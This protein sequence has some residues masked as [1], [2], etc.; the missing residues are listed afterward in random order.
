[1]LLNLVKKI[2]FIYIITFYSLFAFADDEEIGRVENV[3]GIAEIVNKET[4]TPIEK[5]LPVHPSDTIVTKDKSLVK[6]LFF[7]GADIILYDN[8][9]LK[10][11]EYKFKLDSNKKNLSGVF[12]D[13]KGKIRFFVKPDKNVENDVKYKTNNAV[14]GIRGTG[15]VIV[16]QGLEKTQLVVTSGTVDFSNPA[17]P[18]K[19]I[20]VKE[21]QW[22]E[23]RGEKPPAP[24]K[25]VTPE[26]IKNLALD[27]PEGFELT[28]SGG[29]E[30]DED[31]KSNETN[32]TP[33]ATPATG[34]AGS[35]AAGD[36]DDD[37]EK[38]ENESVNSS[39][40]NE[41]NEVFRLGPTLSVGLYQYFSVG[42]EARLFRFLGLSANIGGSPSKMNMKDF[43]NSGKK[44]NDNSQTPINDIKSS[45]MH[46]EVRAV[47]YPFR[48]SFFIGSAFGLRK[49]DLEAN[50]CV[51]VTVSSQNFCVPANANLKLNTTYFTP[52]FGWLF[53]WDNGFTIGTELGAQIPLHAS[54]Q[55]NN[56]NLNTQDPNAYSQAI[57]SATYKNFQ[58]TVQNNMSDYFTHQVL[59]FWNILKIGWLF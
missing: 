22:G 47:I 13:I 7:D 59:P 2:I 8:S 33:P 21:N 58:N 36:D 32:S 1:M 40:K 14:M 56:V 10:I 42:L 4:R 6:I 11:K 29:D 19:I 41:E 43:P 20:Q 44:I 30:K 39:S 48:G 15:G 5:D 37:D 54:G 23:M 57:N 53:V 35:A 18:N 17:A 55:S 28:K 45:F 3:I 50:T 24:P 26:L 25:P 52:Q 34:A 27:L 51:F 12:E 16:A 38:E 31:T 9:E 46:F 49:I